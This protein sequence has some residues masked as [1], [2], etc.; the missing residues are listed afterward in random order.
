MAKHILVFSLFLILSCANFGQLK[1]VA[2]FPNSLD[3][4]SGIF[5]AQ[6]S[7][8][9]ALEDGGNKDKIYKVDF[10]GNIL[11]T[12]KVKNAKNKDW[13]DIATDKE[14]NVY[15]ADTGN[16]DNDR[17][18]LVIYK[19]PDPEIE[20]GDKIDAEKIEFYYP[21]QKKFPP[22]KANRFYDVEA[23]FHAGSKLYLVTK[24]RANPFNGE[25]YIYSL[26][27]TGGK[28][29]ATLVGTMKV[30]E[31]WKTCQ[32][33]A[34]TISPAQKKIV[35]L[36]YGKL[37]VFTNFMMDDFSKG[38][39]TTIDLGVRTQLESICFADEN[40]LLLADEVSHGSGGNL[41]SYQLSD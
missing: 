40:T 18:D 35:A 33:T 3:E 4:V 31:D 23:L 1:H 21:E 8:I 5:Y 27:D 32:I 26:P 37:F 9:W 39:M 13:E 34:I 10:T 11:K 20:K 36:G 28:Y 25:A 16:N 2:D 19:L 29:E 7:T 24:N 6:D 38:T 17:K 14:G 30:C 15:I 12:F 41:Y 22:K